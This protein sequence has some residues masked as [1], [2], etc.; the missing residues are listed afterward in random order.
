MDVLEISAAPTLKRENNKIC[1]ETP[2]GHF[3]DTTD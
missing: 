1:A 3:A 2:F